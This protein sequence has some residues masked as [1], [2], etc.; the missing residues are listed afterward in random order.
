MKGELNDI[1]Q[2]LKG[3]QDEADEMS[4]LLAVPS[5]EIELSKGSDFYPGFFEFTVFQRPQLIGSRKPVL[6]VS[7][8]ALA[9]ME[10]IDLRL[11][12]QVALY[13]YMDSEDHR[14]VRER[15]VYMFLLL[16]IAT[17]VF[18]GVAGVH[19]VA[20]YG[21]AF[22][23]LCITVLLLFNAILRRQTAA[24]LRRFEEAF[25]A[26]GQ[27]AKFFGLLRE[28]MPERSF[29]RKWAQAQLALCPQIGTRL[30]DT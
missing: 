30:S 1:W 11:G 20:M 10:E 7:S 22:G 9:G 12:V 13:L 29:G 6:P 26:E 18:I 5:V 2:R 14:I 15:P 28:V 21:I 25:H 27:T 16:L 23:F 19:V 8:E 4:H 3:L 24:A 17:S